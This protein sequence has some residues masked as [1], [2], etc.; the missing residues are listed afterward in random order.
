MYCGS[1]GH[2]ESDTTEQL[3]CNKGDLYAWRDIGE[4]GTSLVLLEEVVG[5]R[6]QGNRGL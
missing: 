2:K 6:A 3:N 4:P 1:W 5:R